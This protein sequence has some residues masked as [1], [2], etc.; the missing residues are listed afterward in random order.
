[1]LVRGIKAS[2]SW[3]F[4]RGKINQDERDDVCAAREVLEETG[5]DAEGMLN[6]EWYIETTM[7][8]QNMRLYIIPGVP[9]DVDFAPRTRGEIGVSLW[10]DGRV[11]EYG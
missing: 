8:N 1:M 10:L 3:S 5:F 11:W 7:R 4:P 6:L 9:M 2:A